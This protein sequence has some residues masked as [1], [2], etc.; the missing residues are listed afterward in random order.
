[1]IL[2]VFSNLNDAMNNLQPP[3][4]RIILNVLRVR[5][6]YIVINGTNAD[7]KNMTVSLHISFSWRSH[8]HHTKGNKNKHDTQWNK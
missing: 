2:E 7:S 1:M 4:P 6:K 3:S 5:R 8:K